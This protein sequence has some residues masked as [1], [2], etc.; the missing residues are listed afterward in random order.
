MQ[1]FYTTLIVTFILGLI[2]RLTSNKYKYI[3]YFFVFVITAIFV[4]VAGSRTGIGDTYFYKHTYE[5]LAQNPVLPE[6]GRDI[7]FVIFQLILISISTNPQ[8]LVFFTALITNVSTVFT[9]YRYHN[10]F[11]LQLFMFITSGYWLTTMNGIRQAMAAAILF[12]CTPLIIKKK[13]WLYCLIVVLLC[14][15]HESALIMI[16]LYFVVQEKP[17]SK[18]IWMMIG[19]LGVGLILY[20]ILEPII[21]EI[22]GN[23][24]YGHYSEF[25]EGGSSFIR[26]FIGL[27]PVIGSYLFKDKLAKEWPESKVFVNMCLINGIILC[28]S[29]YNWIFARLTYY[30][31]PYAFV[32]LPYILMQWPNLKQKRLLYYGFLVCYFIFM[33][34]EQVIQGL[35]L[36]YQSII[37]LF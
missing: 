19:F 37:S 26:A 3:K 15:I 34:F 24:N 2:T 14:S 7:G 8:F 9:M 31:Q 21:F 16:P 33:Y 28:F 25:D 29:M 10:Y 18:K 20:D 27:L 4:G 1:V 17:W 5:L 23:T 36:G 6:D 30:F 11:E 13:F 12:A 22:L 35:G 32:L